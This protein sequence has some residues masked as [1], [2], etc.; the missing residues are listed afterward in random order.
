M[1]S[2]PASCRLY[3]WR[4]ILG[5]EAGLY[6]MRNAY[7]GRPYGRDRMLGAARARRREARIA[8]LREG[9]T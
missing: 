5:G 7:L 4:D 8:A 3:G 6:R 2:P 9:R 1:T